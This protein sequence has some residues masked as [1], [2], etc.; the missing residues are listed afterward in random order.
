MAREYTMIERLFKRSKE[1][2]MSEIEKRV[3]EVAKAMPDEDLLLDVA[4]LF[5]VFG[6]SSRI[7][8]ISALGVAELC[9]NDIATVLNMTVSAV[10]HQLRILR[11]NKLVKSRKDGKEVYYSLDDEH[12]RMLFDVAKAHIEE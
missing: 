6:D 10:S 8:I 4:E 2:R 9:V 11:T 12:V 5:K 3:E 7:K 1:K